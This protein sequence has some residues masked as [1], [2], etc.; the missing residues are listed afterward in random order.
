[1]SLVTSAPSTKKSTCV[2]DFPVAALACA[3]IATGVP[4][5]NVVPAVGLVTTTPRRPVGG[6]AGAFAGSGA[7][8]AVA[9]PMSSTWSH[10]GRLGTLITSYVPTIAYV[11]AWN[12]CA[13]VF[14]AI[15][16]NRLIWRVSVSSAPTDVLCCA[17]VDPLASS[18]RSAENDDALVCC[19][20]TTAASIE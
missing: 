6:G 8:C 3:L 11:T 19:V 16:S 1:V 7:A 9:G 5:T 12:V 14:S 10:A 17:I 13:P 2:I 18:M 20:T 15:H 4:A